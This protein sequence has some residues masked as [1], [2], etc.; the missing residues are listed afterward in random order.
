VNALLAN[1][2]FTPSANY[3]ASFTIATSVDDGIAPAIT[4]VKNMT[5]TAVNDAPVLTNNSLTIAEGGSVVLSGTDLSASDADDAAASLTFA[6]S[7]VSG[8]QFELVASPGIAI[9]SFTQAQVSGGEVR[10]VHDGGEAAPSYNVTVS[11]AAL[12]DG[13]A[14]AT[15]SFTNQNDAPSLVNNRL[16]LSRGDSVVL[17]SSSLS[18]SDVDNPSGS[19]EFT[20]SAVTG[21]QFELVSS[22][23]I[24]V[25]S[26]TQAQ[27]SGG[28]VR[29][30]HDGGAAAP[31]YNAIVSDG[32]L[33]DGPVSATIKFTNRIDTVEPV[34][35]P[36][37][38]GTG[39][40]TPP[41]EVP[42]IG[43]GGP[44]P[45][46]NP[47]PTIGSVST[48]TVGTGGPEPSN[49]THVESEILNG[50]FPSA[51]NT[52][53]IL[54][55]GNIG[56]TSGS[57][58]SDRP[59]GEIREGISTRSDAP[60]VTPNLELDDPMLG[61]LNGAGLGSVIDGRGF[62]K[63]M[64]QLREEVDEETN[65]DKVV[66]GS[67]LTLTTGFSI[68]YILWL[69]RGEVLLTSLL[70]SLP[71]W[72]LID[73][74][75]VLSSLGKRLDEDEDDDSIEAAVR[76]G[77]ELPQ[78]VPVPEQQDGTTSVKWRLV[79]QPTDAVPENSL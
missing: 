77:S 54:E 8:G 31:S 79:M 2:T 74:L 60:L 45:V 28:Q 29:F 7:G 75:P 1:V 43:T 13:P 72:R 10:F 32:T 42:I 56:R 18:A 3:N 51:G 70:A 71:A 76:R 4:G 65:L 27:V 15:I 22:P 21:G 53:D 62:V 44:T 23:G 34:E 66:V 46:D 57:R 78:S 61:T 49:T 17:S 68:G 37:P 47:T 16:T 33:S 55:L 67:T 63:A 20:V 14:S 40:P 69:L 6:V 38:P 39:L 41:V 59:S 30:V 24:A 35:P 11:D 19:L 50:E 26:F 5:A 58:A 52:A 9:T 25:T 73:P 36:Q 12:L 64:D 48:G